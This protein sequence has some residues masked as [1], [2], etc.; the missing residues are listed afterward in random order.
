MSEIDVDKELEAYQSD[1]EED[2]I[3][4]EDFHIGDPLNAPHAKIYTT[5]QLHYLVHEG[6]IDLSP[7]YQRDVVWTEGKQMKLLDSIYRN[8]YVP[9]IVMVGDKESDGS[10]TMRCVDGK[11]RLTSIVKFMDGSLPY[12]DPITKK[13][14]YYTV[15]KNNKNKRKEV[16]P[17]WKAEF[18]QKSITVVEYVDLNASM[19]RD[20]FQRVQ[21]GMPLTAAEKL[22]AISSPWATWISDIDMQH[23]SSEG[24]MTENINVD[25]KRGRNFQSIAQVVYC[26]YGI[27]DQLVPTASKLEV[28]LSQEDPPPKAF[29]DA[30]TEVFANYWVLT[31]ENA[32]NQAFTKMTQ[33]L[34]PLEFVFI[35]V[36]LYVMKR[37]TPAERAEEAYQMRLFIR[38]RFPDIRV[39]ADIV[40]TLWT[41]IVD[42]T[43]RYDTGITFDTHANAPSRKTKKRARAVDQGEVSDRESRRTS[44]R[45]RP[46]TKK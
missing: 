39:R 13:T 17:Q 40:R 9:P 24:S 16:P 5:Q 23:I 10:I 41:F 21:L 6:F 33:R 19:E 30:I 7:P 34:S 44:T 1:L 18:S 11:Q 25:I 45:G 38:K 36:L 3:D 35:G 2:E 14:W 22:Q 8:F 46:R 26:C 28:F 20:I 12:R 43:E 32:Y 37:C 29:K 4:P 27:P 15:S 31:S 42:I